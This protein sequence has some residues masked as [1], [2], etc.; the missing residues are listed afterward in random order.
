MLIVKVFANEEQIDE[1]YVQ[2]VSEKYKNGKQ[3]YEIKKPLI[4]DVKISHEF[5]KG[6]VPLLAKVFNVLNKCGYRPNKEKNN[7]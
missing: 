2:N 3:M 4:S 1:I 7:G 5:S 6:Y